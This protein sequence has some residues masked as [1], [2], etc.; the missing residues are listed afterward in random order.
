MNAAMPTPL[1]DGE[2]RTSHN[3]GELLDRVPLTHLLPP[4]QDGKHC[5]DAL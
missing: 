1:T 2:L 4:D 5:L 3:P